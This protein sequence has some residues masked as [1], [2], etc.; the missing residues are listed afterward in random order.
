MRE[1][2]GSKCSVSSSTI[3]TLCCLMFVGAI[4]SA[5]INI[6]NGNSR[7]LDRNNLQLVIE[8][9]TT[10]AQAT[11]VTWRRNGSM[12]TTGGGFFI[13]GE[14]TQHTGNPPCAD[15]MYRVAIQ[16][17]GYLPGRYT[18]TVDNANTADPGVTSPVF[19]VQ[20]MHLNINNL[21]LLYISLTMLPNYRINTGV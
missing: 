15:Q 12:I 9:I 6:D 7:L 16:T 20:G 14:S 19:E 21:Y 3:V 13:G 2:S 1:I 4:T 8:G 18:Y 10:G 5:T 17:N 11:S